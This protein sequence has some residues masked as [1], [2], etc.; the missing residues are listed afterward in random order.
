ML[1]CF[2]AMLAGYAGWLAVQAILAGYA[3][4]SGWL[5]WLAI[6]GMLTFYGG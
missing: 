1:A 3:A 5:C 6:L 4:C 2:P